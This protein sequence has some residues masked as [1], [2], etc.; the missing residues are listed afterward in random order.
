MLCKYTISKLLNIPEYKVEKIVSITDKEIHIKLAPYKNNN[1]V[2]SECGKIHTK[3][4]HSTDIT[5][6]EDLRMGERRIFLHIPK[7]KYK[8]AES[9]KIKTEA[10]SWIG[11]WERVTKRFA[12]EVNRLTAITTNKEAGWYLGLDDE[13]IYRIDKMILDELSKVKL[14][15]TPGS[16]NISVDEVSYRKYHRYLTNVIDAD[17][18]IITWNAKGRKAEALDKYYESLGRNKCSNL[19]SVALDGARTYIS[20]TKKYAVKALIVLDRFHAVQKINRALDQVRK[21]ELKKARNI[22]DAEFVELA[23][24]K[25][26]FVLLKKRSNL[27]ER[28]AVTLKRLCEVN[29]PIYQA[30]LLK[31][32]FLQIY[33]SAD[34]KQAEIQIKS[35]VKQAEESSLKIFQELAESVKDKTEY[36]LN[37][38]KKRI[39][40]DLT[41]KLN[42]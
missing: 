1:A 7:R 20:S 19:E 16:V 5:I 38:F 24:C 22:K 30:M 17:E 12:H 2:C 36:I 29:E 21:D 13:K 34:I 11:K 14:E 10:I 37:W 35:W 9:A 6:A 4:Y 39:Q 42:D 26:R 25:Q 32:S 41:T 23:G 8:C 33:E 15:P 3:G 31:E 40:K 27:T 18:K 28:Q